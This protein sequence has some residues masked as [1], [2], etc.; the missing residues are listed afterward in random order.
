MSRSG[1]WI[2]WRISEDSGAE[3]HVCQRGHGVWFSLPLPCS[4]LDCTI[5]AM[6]L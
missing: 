6:F 2:C 1:S 4:S 3:F 5:K